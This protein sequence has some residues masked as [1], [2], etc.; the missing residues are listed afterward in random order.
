MRDILD[1][2]GISVSLLCVIHCLITPFLVFLMPVVGEFLSEQWFHATIIAIVFPVA[3]WALYNGY[4]LHRLQRVLWLGA[5]GL[6]FISAAIW[7]GH[8]NTYGEF[9]FMVLAGIML[10]AAHWFNL[11]ACS[12]H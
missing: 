11:R 8:E 10:S 7:V 3:V 6:L 12:R 9:F 2:V 1:R 5:L 4:R